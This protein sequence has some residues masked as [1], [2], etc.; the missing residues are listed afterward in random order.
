MSYP[1]SVPIIPRSDAVL[2]CIPIDYIPFF[3]T[4]FESMQRRQT[5]RTDA[6]FITAYQVFA[7][8]EV[9]M[10]NGCIS[11]LIES[12]N[13]LYRLLDA[14]L[15]GR[16]YTLADD[17]PLTI[18]PVIPAVPVLTLGAQPSLLSRAKRINEVVENALNGD[19]FADLSNNTSM[20]AQL[21]T[22]IEKLETS[23]GALDDDM[24]AQLE[25]I[26]GLLA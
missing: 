5:W 26:V 1:F 12:N 7:Q 15:F 24:L 22:I 11:D 10:T 21:Q 23:G 3:R 9:D 8:I 6:D 14:A 17:D 2:V 16:S 25:L 20:R 4:F 18:Y 13:R 19:I